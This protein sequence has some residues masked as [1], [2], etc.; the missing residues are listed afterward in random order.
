MSKLF[1]AL[2]LVS[3][4]SL[5]NT[6]NEHC[7]EHVLNGAPVSA[8]PQDSTQYICKTN[9]AVHYRYDTK[10]AEY[11]A[12]RVTLAD[13]S[14]SA[15]RR[16]DFRPDPAIPR[17]HQSQLIDY[18]A[19][20]YDRGHLAAGANNTASPEVMSESFFLSNMVPQNP[21]HNRGIWRILESLVRDWVRSGKD[22]YVISGTLYQTPYKQIGPNQVGVPTHL[23]KVVV[24]LRDNKG[25]AF[26]LP[27][28]PLPVRDLPQYVTT[29]RSVEQQT[30]LNFHPEL[31]TD[32]EH[33]ETA[34]DAQ[35][36][37]GLLGK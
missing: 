28:A 14:G 35:A 25:I 22:I 27:N 24:D 16:D 15:V 23:W 29:I 31:P 4:S 32:L 13:I 2:M 36:W 10:T 37:P 18:A 33:I 3:F 30:G 26:V 19:S 21:N 11:V 1:A 20:G 17:E 5:A 34:V 7:S 8:L 12:E 6:I 9:Y